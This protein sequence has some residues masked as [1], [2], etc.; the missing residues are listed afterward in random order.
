VAERFLNP[1]AG[2]TSLRAPGLNEGADIVGNVA[3]N[4]PNVLGQLA[5]MLLKLREPLNAASMAIPGGQAQPTMSIAPFIRGAGGAGAN[6][7]IPLMQQRFKPRQ[8]EAMHG[9]ITK[10]RQDMIVN[11]RIVSEEPIADPKQFGRPYPS[12]AS[13]SEMSIAAA[14][15][16]GTQM[17]MWDQIMARHAQNSIRNRARNMSEPIGELSAGGQITERNFMQA[18]LNDVLQILIGAKGP[19]QQTGW[20]STDLTPEQ[21]R[22]VEGPGARP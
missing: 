7:T 8:I 14:M 5:Q 19:K 15:P 13:D 10:G 6:S 18:M 9:D 17:P 16:S 3:G 1:P 21:F 2:Q 22:Q 12:S 11:K 20:R 4:D